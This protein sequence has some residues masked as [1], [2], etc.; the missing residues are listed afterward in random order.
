MKSDFSDYLKFT[1]IIDG[2]HPSVKDFAHQAAGGASTDREKA[3]KLYYAVRDAIRY[4]PYI[5]DLT[6]EAMRASTTL[7]AKRAWCV[8]KAALMCACCRTLGIPS[9]LGYANVKNHLSTKRLRKTLKTDIFYWHGYTTV[10]IDGKWLK[11]TPTFNIEL[12][13]RFGLK[14]L[15]FDGKSDSLLQPFDLSG[16]THMEYLSF[17]GEFTD[18]PLEKIKA[19]F[20][21]RYTAMVNLKNEDFD[22]DALAEK[23]LQKQIGD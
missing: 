21:R 23:A 9:G 14:A 4:N 20:E 18:V 10:H 1:P 13:E 11:A 8:T 19:T 17:R 2:D 7:A 22:K 15:E 3:V 16:Q 5:V 6:V 12:C